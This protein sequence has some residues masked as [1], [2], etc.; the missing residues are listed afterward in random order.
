VF[1]V[2]MTDNRGQSLD[3]KISINEIKGKIY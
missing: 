3:T 1:D 2:T